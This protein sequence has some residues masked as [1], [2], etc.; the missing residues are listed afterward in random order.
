[1]GHVFGCFA[2]HE[3][4]SHSHSAARLSCRSPAAPCP[5]R[6]P[7]VPLPSSATSASRPARAPA[8]PPW[9]SWHVERVFCCTSHGPSAAWGCMGQLAN[10]PPLART[11]PRRR[12]RQDARDGCAAGPAD[13]LAQGPGACMHGCVHGWARSGGNAGRPGGVQE[14]GRAGGWRAPDCCCIQNFLKALPHRLPILPPHV[15]G[16]WAHFAESH[17]ERCPRSWGSKPVPSP[18]MPP[19]PPTPTA[20]RSPPGPPAPQAWRCPPRCT[21]CSTPPPLPA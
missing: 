5:C 3:C 16:C 2:R 6:P 9:V 11:P 21:R 10:A 13:L 14:A 19:M 12:V 17:G 20:R 8:A 18:P 15:Q 7:A 1:M 4:A